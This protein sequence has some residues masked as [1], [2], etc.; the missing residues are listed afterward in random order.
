LFEVFVER[1]VPIMMKFWS[2]FLGVL[3]PVLALYELAVVG[4]S[5]CFHLSTLPP[6]SPLPVL[7][8]TLLFVVCG[9]LFGQALALV[10]V[11]V[12]TAHCDR[13]IGVSRAWGIAWR[14]G[15]SLLVFGCFVGICFGLMLARVSLYCS[16]L[17]NLH[18]GSHVEPMGDIEQAIYYVLVLLIIIASSRI[19]FLPQTVLAEGLNAGDAMSRALELSDKDWLKIVGIT[20]LTLGVAYFAGVVS[21]S[22]WSLWFSP[23]LV[24][25]LCLASYCVFYAFP[26]VALCEM[27]VSVVMRRTDLSR[28][29]FVDEL[30]P[31]DWPADLEYTP[32]AEK[33]RAEEMRKTIS[34]QIKSV[35]EVKAAKAAAASS[36]TLELDGEGPLKESDRLARFLEAERVKQAQREDAEKKQGGA[37]GT[38]DEADLGIPEEWLRP[39]KIEPKKAVETTEIKTDDAYKTQEFKI[40]PRPKIEPAP[41]PA[42]AESKAP[43]PSLAAPQP[44]RVEPTLEIKHDEPPKP[45]RSKAP[46]LEIKI[47]STDASEPDADEFFEGQAEL[48]P[49]ETA[50]LTAPVEPAPAADAVEQTEPEVFE[51]SAFETPIPSSEAPV[52]SADVVEPDAPMTEETPL[53]MPT[54]PALPPPPPPLVLSPLPPPPPPPPWAQKGLPAVPAPSGSFPTPPPPPPWA[55]RP[56]ASASVSAAE[57]APS[58]DSTALPSLKMP[59]ADSVPPPPPPPAPWARKDRSSDDEDNETRKIKLPPKQAEASAVTETVEPAGAAAVDDHPVA[60]H[61]AHDAAVVREDESRHEA[62]VE[63][64]E[65]GRPGSVVESVPALLETESP[66]A[67]EQA[68]P[69]ADRD[70]EDGAPSHDDA[71]GST[72][73]VARL[74]LSDTPLPPPPPPPPWANASPAPAANT[75]RKIF[76]SPSKEALPSLPPVPPPP[77][78]FPAV[79]LPGV[80]ALP[81]LHTPLLPPMPAVEPA[82]AV[83]ESDF[84]DDDSFDPAAESVQAAAAVPAAAEVEPGEAAA[85]EPETTASSS[86]EPAPQSAEDERTRRL[87]AIRERLARSRAERQGGSDNAGAAETSVAAEDRPVA[88]EADATKVGVR[89][90]RSLAREKSADES[91]APSAVPAEPPVGPTADAAAAQPVT[92]GPRVSAVVAAN[93]DIRIQQLAARDGLLGSWFAAPLALDDVMQGTRAAQQ[94]LSS[95]AN[96]ATAR[97]LS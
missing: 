21:H 18:P 19:C 45:P 96:S 32:G 49:L 69:V 58:A 61:E 13:R 29:A 92:E 26:L 31:L 9:I 50:S 88:G 14:Y 47:A 46:V 97:D 20:L 10:N 39:R 44:A 87:R 35:A 90:W 71:A 64:V 43:A 12:L 77:P 59:W 30:P 76:L 82:S 1:S 79:D 8:N 33:A 63:D 62:V 80:P 93:G 55:A 91:A 38:V 51:G 34:L 52:E 42:P 85:V 23:S 4:L 56:E 66:P 57:A 16:Q 17:N 36:A 2:T 68:E 24:E 5:W 25:A 74:S 11:V 67:A 15:R 40:E 65:A 70:V 48:P 73:V 95:K 3:L 60:V 83:R 89:R 78:V 53:P 86:D 41:E 75:T 94:Y 54:S 22:V 84:I 27:Y 6:E 37:A 28:P 72:S 81:P 7:L